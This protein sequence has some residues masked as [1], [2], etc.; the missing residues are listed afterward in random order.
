MAVVAA[1]NT[2]IEE[3][4]QSKEQ[5]M[6]SEFKEIEHQVTEKSKKMVKQTSAWQNKKE[7]YDK[8]VEACAGMHDAIAD[9][10][11]QQE[12]MKT[13]KVTAEEDCA[14][15]QQAA[16]A[17]VAE[18]DEMQRKFLAGELSVDSGE[19]NTGSLADQLEVSKATVTTSTTN[20][21]QLE[22]KIK[23][24]RK[25]QEAKQKAE[26]KGKKE[27]AKMMSEQ[28]K[29][30]T[31]LKTITIN[32]ME[33][34][35]DEAQEQALL[36]KKTELELTISQLQ[37]KVD[38]LSSRL[39]RIQF[40]YSDPAKNFDRSKV[41]GLVA[42]LLE[43]KDVSTATA[44]ETTAGGSLYSAVVDTDTT[45]KMLLK[46]GK[47]KK[48]VT[49]IPLNKIDTRGS[50]PDSKLKA[51]EKSVGKTNVSAALSLIEFESDVEPAMK[52]V[53]GRSFVCRDS[54]SAREVTFNKDIR[55]RCVTLDGDEF[56]PT[57][58]L[59][60][61]S[62][63]QSASVLERLQSLTAAKKELE[64]HQQLLARIDEQLAAVH[65]T[66]TAYHQLKNK[67]EM[68]SHETELIKQR[69]AASAHSQ[70]QSELQLLE[71]DINT[72]RESL[73]AAIEEKKTA[74]ARCKELQSSIKNFEKDRAKQMKEIEATVA[75]SKKEAATATKKAKA[76]A[77]KV[78]SITLEMGETVKEV[79]D[80]QEQVKER[81]AALAVAA[82]EVAELET[83]A[84]DR[85]REYEEAKLELDSR[86][87]RISE[88]EKQIVKLA[89]ARNA[90]Q[91]KAEKADLE[92]KRVAHKVTRME[93]D[94][95][96]ASRLIESL[97][98]KFPWIE[99]EKHLFGQ[100][101][102]EYDFS[103]RSPGAAREKLVEL[104]DEQDKYGQQRLPFVLHC[105][106]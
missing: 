19:G 42:E 74:E 5:E 39:S 106:T 65:Q 1:Q 93:K 31:E 70:Q 82:T 63:Q 76:T 71:T 101:K 92:A 105:C 83:L 100:Q 15:H 28:Q 97:V 36:S 79:G 13:K 16:D 72:A 85:K 6:G 91:K 38:E 103:R 11:K 73:V 10:G 60:G 88:C 17:A 22:T 9:A 62:R 102:S 45:G 51:A 99:S 75:K 14:K 27:Y 47:L 2:E 80:M 40:D 18:A 32:L 43:L 23:H 90:A 58:T 66:A 46:N 55:T 69:I 84:G 35:Y 44:L 21:K 56:K 96:A 3:L 26:G 12:T 41:K 78:E 64:Q 52:Y 4:T 87:Q 86:R 53:F 48:R 89:K 81:E 59:S 50:I 94:S 61:G 77:Q 98:A 7:T 67:K 54:K 30:E 37:A 24:L 49:I 33:L 104:R 68:K 8:E 57:G 25:E 95:A 34:D 29:L 20:A